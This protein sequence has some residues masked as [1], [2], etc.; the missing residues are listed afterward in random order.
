M[1]YSVPKPEGEAP[2]AEGHYNH[3][4]RMPMHGLTILDPTYHWL[5]MLETMHAT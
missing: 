4:Y 3:R 5:N 1:S 2:R